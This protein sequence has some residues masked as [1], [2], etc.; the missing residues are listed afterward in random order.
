MLRVHT[1]TPSSAL[2]ANINVFQCVE[3]AECN[4]QSGAKLAQGAEFVEQ[5]L[6]HHRQASYFSA[7][8]LAQLKTQMNAQICRTILINHL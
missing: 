7:N 1:D 3:F 4:N 5:H 2:S 8:A 6:I